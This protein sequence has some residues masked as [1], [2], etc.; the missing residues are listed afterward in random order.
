[1]CAWMVELWPN[2]KWMAGLF[3]RVKSFVS[4]HLGDIYKTGELDREAIV[5]IFASTETV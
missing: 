3:E 2:L 1:M 5:V 4:R